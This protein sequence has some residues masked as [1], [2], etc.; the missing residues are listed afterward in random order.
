[1]SADNTKAVTPVKKHCK[2]VS[3]KMHRIKEVGSTICV[4]SVLV[5]K[6]SCMKYNTSD[7]KIRFYCTFNQIRCYKAL[8]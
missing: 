1:M 7:I 3:L 2:S 6:I 4:F 8:K 5:H